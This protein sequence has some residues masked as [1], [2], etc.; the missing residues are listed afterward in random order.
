ML[1]IFTLAALLASAAPAALAQTAAASS[2]AQGVISYPQAFFAEQRPVTAYDMVGRLPGFTLDTGDNVRGFEGAAGNV[3]IDGG[4]PT[5][6]TDTLDD[7]LR[8]I[9]ASQVDHIQLIR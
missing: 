4:R 7:I 1:R 6:K 8:R 5:S 9:P 2:S 3:L